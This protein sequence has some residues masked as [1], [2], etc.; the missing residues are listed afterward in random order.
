V[1]NLLGWVASTLVFAAFCAREML[2]LRLLA[3]ASNL[4]FIGYG[5]GDRLWPILFL[6]AAMLP[7]NLIRLRQLMTAPAASSQ[8]ARPSPTLHRAVRPN[9]AEPPLA[10]L[11]R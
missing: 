6:H 2:V 10:E 4:A 1:N 3:V 9:D 5:Y 11:G 8:T 7:I